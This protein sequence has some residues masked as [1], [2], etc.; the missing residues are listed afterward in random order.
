[1][2]QSPNTAALQPRVNSEHQET[3]T[4]ATFR[5][6][7]ARVR[8]LKTD[9]YLQS[10]GDR[11]GPVSTAP[12]R[13]LGAQGSSEKRKGFSR[14]ILYSS[15]SA[16]RFVRNGVTRKEISKQRQDVRNVE[17]YG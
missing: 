16:L 9:G 4:T 15:C 3:H 6:E 10:R 12:E 7:Q 5:A 1:M 2:T 11:C 17:L 13:Q 8:F 14:S